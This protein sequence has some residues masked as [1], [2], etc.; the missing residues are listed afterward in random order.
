M[1]GEACGCKQMPIHKDSILGFSPCGVFPGV[2]SSQVGRNVTI[3][4]GS[5]FRLVDYTHGP[6]CHPTNGSSR[7][8]DKVNRQSMWAVYLCLTV[9]PCVWRSLVIAY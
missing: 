1:S 6:V 2:S 9:E 8:G 5:R 7:F 4:Q 3:L